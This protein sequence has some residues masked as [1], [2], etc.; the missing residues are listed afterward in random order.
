MLLL[1]RE[2]GSGPTCPATSVVRL[3]AGTRHAPLRPEKEAPG[4]RVQPR[5]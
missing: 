4:Q 1:T 5:Q 3:G 2:G